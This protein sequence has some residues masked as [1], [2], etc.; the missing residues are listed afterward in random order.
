MNALRCWPA[1]M[2]A[3][4]AM[5]SPAHAGEF[6]VIGGHAF[7]WKKPRAAKCKAVTAQD[8]AK[9]RK[10][11]FA[12]TGAFGLPLAYHTCTVGPR[13]E[14]IVLDSAAHCQEALETM[15]ANGD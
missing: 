5:A 12:P 3:L 7:D 13:S 9:F 6:A 11:E 8:A 14:F 2:L 10:C 15:Q 4:C 1:L